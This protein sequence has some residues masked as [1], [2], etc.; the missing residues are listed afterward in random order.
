M[1]KCLWVAFLTLLT[2]GLNAQ[3][4]PKKCYQRLQG[5]MDERI[6][7]TLNLIKVNDSVFVDYC[8]TASPAVARQYNIHSGTPGT[9]GGKITTDGSFTLKA[10]YDDQQME[11]RGKFIT[12]HIIS[13]TW[14]IEKNEARHKFTVS[15]NYPSG[16]LPLSVYYQTATKPL[17]SKKTTPRAYIEQCLVVPV[18]SSNATSDTIRNRIMTLFAGGKPASYDPQILVNSL[19]QSYF[20]NY[21][22]DNVE[23]LKQ[24]AAV[25]LLNW[26]LYKLMHIVY[27]EKSILSFYTESYAFTGGAHGLGAQDYKVINVK[28]GKIVTSGDIFIRDFEPAL[29]RLL[30]TKLKHTEGLG[31]E[32]KL[33]E[34]AEYFSDEVAPTNNLYITGS[35]IGFFYNHYEIAPYSHG[36]TDI[37]LTWEE[38]SPILKPGSIVDPLLK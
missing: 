27:N 10:S 36:F 18:I 17:I 32:D 2:T 6:E 28:T 25:A 7:V 22:S 24:Q 13:G 29:T 8:L 1:M 38:L 12:N 37:F 11:I 15:E 34:K 20:K 35:G 30:T 31:P 9:A 26:D 14:Q 21:L 19:Q 23:L 16:I 33:S 4:L 3:T 5:F